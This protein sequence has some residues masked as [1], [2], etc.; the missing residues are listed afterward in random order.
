MAKFEVR[1]IRILKVYK[2]G[3]KY[4]RLKKMLIV[5]ATL[6]IFS[7]IYNTSKKLTI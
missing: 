6:L 5:N 7:K 2:K 1:H 4:K 3:E